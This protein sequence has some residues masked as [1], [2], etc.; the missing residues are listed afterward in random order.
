MEHKQRKK[1]YTA[2]H[3]FDVL[4]SNPHLVMVEHYDSEKFY[5]IFDGFDSIG[6]LLMAEDYDSN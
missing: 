1:F 6:H 3:A 2:F 5:D 4:D